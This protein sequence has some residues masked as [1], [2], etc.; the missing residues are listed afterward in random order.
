MEASHVLIQQQHNNNN[1]QQQ[2]QCRV[3]SSADH[4]SSYVGTAH[5]S[6]RRVHHDAAEPLTTCLQSQYIAPVRD[7]PSPVVSKSQLLPPAAEPGPP[8]SPGACSGPSSVLR[9]CTG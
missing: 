4:S 9:S 6:D 5:S 8:A 7:E 1:N 3:S 2:Q